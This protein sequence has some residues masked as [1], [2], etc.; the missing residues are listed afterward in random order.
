MAGIGKSTTKIDDASKK[1]SIEELE[2][3]FQE[4][5][6]RVQDK[7]Q[8]KKDK[9]DLSEETKAE[10]R[11]E[12]SLI[13]QLA[14]TISVRTTSYEVKA[15]YEDWYNKASNMAARFGSVIK[16]GKPKHTMDD[17]KGLDDVKALISSFMFMAE[18]PDALKHYGIEG[19]LGLLLY[20]P[21]GTGKTMFAEAIANKLNLPLFVVTPADIFKSYV[22]ESEKAVRQIFQELEMCPEGAILFVDEC[23]SIFSKRSS[24]TKDYKAAVTTELLQRIN[25]FGVDGSKRILVGAT[26]RPDIID[27][28]YLRYKRFSHLVHVTPP[29]NNAIK[30][31]I[32]SKLKKEIALLDIT[33][34]EIALMAY[35]RMGGNKVVEGETMIDDRDAYY[36]AADI[37]GIIEEACRLAL[38]EMERKQTTAYVPLTRDMF[39]K[40]FEKNPPSISRKVYDEYKNFKK[41]QDNQE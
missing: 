3:R 16:S 35:E 8:N 38:E 23:E 37:C 18:H 5:V 2:L 11:A 10:L 30:A 7:L 20:G 12:Y 29:D 27:S 13:A 31:I 26:N 19:G 34:D 28:A 22:G 6:K 33:K 17:I 1:S 39:E 25:G 9:N 36:S 14:K 15:K 4:S 40:A 32:D 41:G 24:D 21:P